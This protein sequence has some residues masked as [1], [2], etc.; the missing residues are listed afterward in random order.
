MLFEELDEVFG[1]SDKIDPPLLLSSATDFGNIDL[2]ITDTSQSQ[3]ASD[4][5]TSINE[6]GLSIRKNGCTHNPK[7]RS[8]ACLD[9]LTDVL[10]KK[11][12]EDKE[13]RNEREKKED[14]CVERAERRQ[15]EMINVLKGA[16]DALARIADTNS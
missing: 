4:I 7:K 13:E 5:E 3:A 12:K 8:K 14:E 10:K 9:D 6:R 1:S 11:W 2:M 16:I 15:E